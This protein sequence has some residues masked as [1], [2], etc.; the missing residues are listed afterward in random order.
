MITLTAEAARAAPAETLGARIARLAPFPIWLAGTLA[1]LAG[2]ATGIV[3]LTFLARRARPIN[4]RAW[5][6]LAERIS[7]EYGLRRT[8]RLLQSRN[9][10]ILV[11]WGFAAPRI[12]LP[13]GAAGWPLERIRVV[14]S[15]E[16]GHIRRGDWLM[17]IAAELL[18][19]V[20]WFNPLVW[21]VC[22]RLRLESE[23]ACD[24]LAI[25]AGIG[26]TEYAH[27]LLQLARD[28]RLADCAWSA[29]LS[30]ARPSTIERRFHAMLNP[31]T[32][33]R[34]V[35]AAGLAATIFA[36]VLLTVPIATFSSIGAEPLTIH[37]VVPAEVIPAPVLPRP[38]APPVSVRRIEKPRPV[39]AAATGDVQGQVLDRSGAL[40][41]GVDVTAIPADRT[42]N[43]FATLTDETGSYAFTSLPAGFYRIRV[44]LPG[45]KILNID[46]VNVGMRPAVVK[47]VLEVAPIAEEV[48]VTAQA[49]S[50]AATPAPA[51]AAVCAPPPPASVP[52]SQVS[53]APS[54]PSTGQT[55]GTRLRLGGNVRQTVLLGQMKPVY[56]VEAKAAQVQGVVIVEIVIGKDGRIIN[57]RLV[58]G[59]PMLAAAA[60]QAI[61]QWCYR[62]TLLNG[63]PVETA[64]VVTV[65]FVLQ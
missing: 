26:T 57:D 27:Q 23:N 10:A 43:G 6:E 55:T 58:S 17:Q 18:R 37:A 15:H 54:P 41:P 22:R 49:G 16:L 21:V 40:V 32:N 11:T 56:P 7:R 4:D 3:R 30:M 59:H 24:D 25:R 65:N 52:P 31:G 13:E 62:P 14:L 2:L 61:D 45:F 5:R 38:E 48:T 35:S 36:A 47:A 46:N 64:G 42:D 44:A 29:A 33:R 12:I 28:F 9:P 51:V 60:R 34:P 19:T 20:Y 50:T 1:G 63:E 39:Q 8:V 53:A